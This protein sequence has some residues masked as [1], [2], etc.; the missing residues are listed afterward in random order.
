LIRNG[1][2][3]QSVREALK[4]AIKFE[5]VSRKGNADHTYENRKE[6]GTDIESNLIS[7]PHP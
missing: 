6:P 4:V 3:L 5:T 1:R 2:L 7:T